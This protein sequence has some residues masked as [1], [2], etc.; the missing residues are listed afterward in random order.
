MPLSIIP[1]Q[2][3]VGLL[4]FR[5]VGQAGRDWSADRLQRCSRYDVQSPT[6]NYSCQCWTDCSGDPMQNNKGKAKSQNLP[7][8]RKSRAKTSRTSPGSKKQTKRASIAVSTV[9]SNPTTM[10]L[11]P[12]RDREHGEGV[13]LSGIQLLT[14]LAADSSTNPILF[15]TS[16][17]AV[18]S[19]N[20]SVLSPD[21]LQGRLQS[22]ALT[23]D[24]YRFRRVTYEYEP[25]CASTQTGAMIL[26]FVQDGNANGVFTN[27]YANLTEVSPSKSIP[28]REKG[29][30]D[31]RYDGDRVWYTEVDTG[32]IAGA[33]QT[34][35]GILMGMPSVAGLNASFGVLRIH[36]VV[37]LFGNVPYLGGV[38]S[39]ASR[40]ERLL[41]G[42]YILKLREEKKSKGSSDGKEVSP[43]LVSRTS[44]VQSASA[45]GQVSSV[46]TSYVAPSLNE[47]YVLVNTRT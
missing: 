4:L 40:E 44:A 11:G 8:A 7:R 39:Q 2:G 16:S 35:Q 46:A 17:T 15:S 27:S 19:V 25:T 3:P 9:R 42:E 10:A 14:V 22:L 34:V 6:R 29:S 36:Y 12:F 5:K 30:L 28:F 20:Q 21:Y 43:V 32:S 13:R 24:R 31:Y 38:V 18:C 26:A 47:R 23:Y 33:R 45:S 37:E 41:A 1:C